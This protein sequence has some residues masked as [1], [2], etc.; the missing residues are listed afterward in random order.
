MLG[1]YDHY[2]GGDHAWGGGGDIKYFFYRY[3]GIGVEGFALNASKT[4]FESSRTRQSHTY[5][6]RINQATP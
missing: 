1:T 6:A 4:G 5:Q 3:F 2:I